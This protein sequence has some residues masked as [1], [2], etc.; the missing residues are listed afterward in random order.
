MKKATDFLEKIKDR[1]EIVVIFNNDGDGICSCALLNKLLEK[2]G[3]KRPY[4]IAQP[5]PMD[6]NILQRI[7]TTV[8][9]KIIFLDIAADQQQSVL[10]KLGSICDIMIVDHHQVFKNMNQQKDAKPPVVVH[11]NPRMEQHDTYKSTSYCIYK[12]CS[13]LADMSDLLW[14][15]GVGMVSD[16]NL[17]DSKDLVKLIKEKYSIEG[18]LYDTKLGRIADMISAARATNM[19]SCEQMVDVMEAA[20]YEEFEKAKNADKMAEA[21]RIIEN[22]TASILADAEEHAERIGKVIFYNIKSRYNLGSSLST[23]I[24]E[25]FP[26]NLLIVYEKT[27]N[28]VKVSGRNQ[29]KNINAGKV[30]QKAAK[31]AEGSGGGHEAAAGATVAADKWDKFR[32]ILIK[33]VNK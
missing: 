4:I 10:K 21:R 7:Q 19:L 5:M 3:R 27:G 14:V 16:Y 8:P 13:K 33:I 23:K 6:R 1:D 15:A 29:G 26:R 25:K 32:E 11:Y 31:D 30:M 28:R 2:T 18:K 20:T 12:I 22:E 17:E 24:S 9:D